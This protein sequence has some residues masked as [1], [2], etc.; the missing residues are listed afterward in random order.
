MEIECN[1]KSI[2]IT[3]SGNDENQ[4]Q[5]KLEVTKEKTIFVLKADQV[6]VD[7]TI[8]PEN[9]N[10]SN[11][12]LKVNS[13]DV[14]INGSI[15]S[16]IDK[17]NEDLSGKITVDYSTYNLGL[18]FKTN[19]TYGENLITKKSLTGGKEITNL[20]DEET[21]TIMTNFMSKASSFEIFNSLS[22]LLNSWSDIDDN[23]MENTCK[24]MC[25]SGDV[26]SI[27]DESGTCYCTDGTEISI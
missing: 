22:G 21:A 4:N 15:K 3:I 12:D 18:E 23:L 8:T 16:T 13:D 20:T 19:T 17:K 10:T 2:Y 14:K 6:N 1:D 9:N 5:L 7:M 24:S 11:I 27:D 26:F 25:P